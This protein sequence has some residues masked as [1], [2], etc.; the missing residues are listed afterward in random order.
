MSAGRCRSELDPFKWVFLLGNNRR[1]VTRHRRNTAKTKPLSCST[2][3][4]ASNACPN[5][6]YFTAPAVSDIYAEKSDVSRKVTVL[7][8]RQRIPE[9][10][11]AHGAEDSPADT[12]V[13]GAAPGWPG[14]Q[15]RG[16]FYS[17]FSQLVHMHTPHMLRFQEYGFSCSPLSWIKSVYTVIIYEYS[18]HSHCTGMEGC[19]THS[20]CGCR[21][22]D[23]VT[24][25][26]MCR[27]I[28]C[29]S[30]LWHCQVDLYAS[31]M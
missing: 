1:T 13:P 3:A 25:C 12:Y 26:W 30:D 23:P 10:S 28:F 15:P 8:L 18:I 29:C 16:E 5:L 17:C 6:L 31:I 21:D 20:A 9:R 22:P 14:L 7:F 2:A 19:H 24:C 27:N 11:G 4:H